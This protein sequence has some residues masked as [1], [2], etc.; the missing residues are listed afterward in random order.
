MISRITIQNFHSIKNL[1]LE[2][3]PINAFVGPNNVGKSNILR[4]INLILGPRWPP[5]ATSPEDKNRDMLDK[6]ILIRVHLNT[7]VKKN[8]YDKVFEVWG[9]EFTYQSQDQNDFVCID[10]SGKVLYTKYNNPLKADNN[11]RGQTPA[12]MVDTRRDLLTELRASQWTLLGK[13]LNTL[14]TRLMEKDGFP[15]KFNDKAKQLTE[16]LME[17]PVK[18]LQRILNE[19]MTGISG[20]QELELS[21]EPPELYAA[22]RAIQIFVSEGPDIPKGKAEDLGQGLQSALVISMARVY[23]KLHQVNPTL[24]LEEPEAFLHP[25]ARRAFYSLIEDTACTKGCQVFYS[26]HSAEFIDMAKPERIYLTRKD[27]TGGT[28]VIHGNPT[29]LTPDEYSELKVL[30]EVDERMREILFSSCVIACEGDAEAYSIPILL[31][32]AGNDPDRNGWAVISTGSKTNLPFVLRICSHFKIP[33]VAA[34]DE[35]SDKSNYADY[36]L[37]LNRKII[38]LVGGSDKCWISDP[39]FEVMHGIDVSSS[40]PRSAVKWAKEMSSAEA[41]KISQPLVDAIAKASMDRAKG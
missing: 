25:Q 39:S 36:Q 41:T 6:P 32:K 18:E 2:T 28:Y 11:L 13:I 27:P 33:C 31:K 30:C 23:Q 3:G 21:F 15:E 38:E 10:Q 24:L 7:P 19:E 12:L 26:T 40:K 5:S 37:P 4:A 22:L 16:Q 20:F 8:Y 1:T 17:D 9:L 29:V 34:Y 14:E 35:D